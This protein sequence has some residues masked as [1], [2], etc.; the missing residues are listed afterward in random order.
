MKWVGSESTPDK[1]CFTTNLYWNRHHQAWIRATVSQTL[2]FVSMKEI[3]SKKLEHCSFYCVD[4]H[5]ITC[6]HISICILMYM[7]H[8]SLNV[9]YDEIFAI[10]SNVLSQLQ[11]KRFRFI[12]ARTRCC[13]QLWTITDIF[14]FSYLWT[15]IILEHYFD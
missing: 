7:I 12:V 15:L 5:V 6:K 4:E 8:V 13:W 3:S 2:F 11:K 14:R 10:L 1:K 9:I